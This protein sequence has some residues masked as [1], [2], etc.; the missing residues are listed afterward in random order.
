MNK[1]D[2]DIQDDDGSND[3]NKYETYIPV[4]YSLWIEG[5]GGRLFQFYVMIHL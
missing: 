3:N 4:S 2:I 5:G 1:D